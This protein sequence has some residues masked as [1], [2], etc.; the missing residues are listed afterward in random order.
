MMMSVTWLDLGFYSL[1]ILV[2]FL[3]P[4]PVWLA[5]LARSVTGGFRSAWPLALGVACGDVLWPLLAVLGVSWIVSEYDQ[6]LA[7]LRWVACLTFIALGWQVIRTAGNEISPNSR[8]TRPGMGAGFI[9][10]VAAILGNPKV[11]LFYL[12]ILPGFFN[13]ANIT[14]ADIAMIVALSVIVPLI[15]NLCFALFIDRVRN[16]IT[17]SHTRR[18]INLV[19][20]W[21]LIVVGLI[22]PLS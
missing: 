18:R 15:G 8:L 5:I 19:A 12:G 3:T 17:S 2:L 22:I 20:G 11:I 14:S 21:A 9:A 4:G 6:L 10:G 13:L 1:A 7:V 16:F